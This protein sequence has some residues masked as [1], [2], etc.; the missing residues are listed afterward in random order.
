MESFSRCDNDLQFVLMC[1][2]RECDI[3][4]LPT[5]GGSLVSSLNTFISEKKGVRVIPTDTWVLI[6]S[7]VSLEHK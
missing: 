2:L 1:E 6:R 3:V 4:V 5:T 7:M